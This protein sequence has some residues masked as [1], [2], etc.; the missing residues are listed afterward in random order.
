MNFDSDEQRRAEL[1]AELGRQ[2]RPRY[3]VA[4]EVGIHPVRFGRMLNGKEPLL[5]WVYASTCQA[6]RMMP[7]RHAESV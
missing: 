3:K 6:L 5:D 4:A 2:M 7:E 1:R